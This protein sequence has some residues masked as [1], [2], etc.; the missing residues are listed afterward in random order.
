MHKILIC[1]SQAKEISNI[2][3]AIIDSDDRSIEGF[4]QVGQVMLGFYRKLLGPSFCIRRPLDLEVI[5]LGPI[6]T[7][8]Q[9]LSACTPSSDK[10]IHDAV[11]SIPNTK[12]PGPD[13][14]N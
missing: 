13:G 2:Y 9:Q 8:E 1:E 7:R 11:F 12:S 3:Y 10:D 6:L 14:G 5:N 4:E